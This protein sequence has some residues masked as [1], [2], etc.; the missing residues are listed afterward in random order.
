MN[1]VTV[2]TRISEALVKKIAL[3]GHYISD[4]IQVGLEL[5]FG[6]SVEK[7]KELMRE[8]G[9]RKRRERAM[10]LYGHK[11]DDGGTNEKT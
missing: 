2:S 6:L 8:H 5:F 9:L 11:E 4:V 3:T 10:K 7:Q 1:K